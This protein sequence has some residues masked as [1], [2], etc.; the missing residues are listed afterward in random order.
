MAGGLWL[1]EVAAK[2]LTDDRMEDTRPVTT[3][4]SSK[5][6]EG[7]ICMSMYGVWH[8]RPCDPHSS[9]DTFQFLDIRW[10]FLL[11]LRYVSVSARLE[12]NT[13]I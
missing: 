7:L 12:Q 10:T 1:L 8:G 11:S 6:T 2:G 3:A 5:S 9:F 4:I 13:V